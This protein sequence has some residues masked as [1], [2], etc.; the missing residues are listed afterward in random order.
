MTP[1]EYVSTSSI[2]IDDGK[3][4]SSSI[5]PEVGLSATVNLANE[6]QSLRS[7]E[8]IQEVVTQCCDSDS[9]YFTPHKVRTRLKADQR[10][11]TSSIVDLAYADTDPMRAQKVLK[12]LIEV[13]E[14]KKLAER[15]SILAYANDFLTRR[16]EV[17]QSELA[18]IDVD[19]AR[20]KSDNLVLDAEKYGAIATASAIEAQRHLDDIAHQIELVSYVRRY[21]QD[22]NHRLLPTVTGIENVSIQQLMASYNEVMIRCNSKLAHSSEQNPLVIDLE[23]ELEALRQSIDESLGNEISRLQLQCEKEETVLALAQSRISQSP[24]QSQYLLSVGREQKVKENLFLYLLQKKEESQLSEALSG[25]HALVIEPPSVG[26]DTSRANQWRL[27]LLAIAVGLILPLIAVYVDLLIDPTVQDISDMEGRNLKILGEI[28]EKMGEEELKLLAHD[29]TLFMKNNVQGKAVLIASAEESREQERLKNGL[30]KA[31]P[32][33]GTSA[34]V[35]PTG[36]VP[37][38]RIV[39]QKGLVLYSADK[40]ECRVDAALM[41]RFVEATVFV[42]TEGKTRRSALDKIAQWTSSGRFPNVAIVVIK[43]RAF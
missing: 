24:I 30:G 16:I 14:A 1:A 2:R 41:A 33:I 3:A 13:Y 27:W 9:V 35:I 40:A 26:V 4:A 31:L 7:L 39:L 38:Y 19:I 20:Y 21:V 17:L 11:R 15:Q 28:S 12:V 18:A 37:P 32:L 5:L 10:H 6:V 43:R 34:D 25:R 36:K 22:N 29:L 8:L 42:I 23:E